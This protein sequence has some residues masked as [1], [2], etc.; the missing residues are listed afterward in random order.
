MPQ[1]LAPVSL[2]YGIETQLIE[3]SVEKIIHQNLPKQYISF[4]LSYFKGDTC[5]ANEII[6][7]SKT[8]PFLNK[9]RIVVVTE[10]EKFLTEQSKQLLGYVESPCKSTVLI[11][12]GT[13]KVKKTTSLFKA[14]KKKN[15]AKAFYAMK[16]P[17]AISWVQKKVIADG[18]EIKHDAAKALVE[19]VGC[20]SKMLMPEV[21]KLKLYT[22][23]RRLI[24]TEDVIKLSSST[25]SFTLFELTDA[26]GRKQRNKALRILD[27][28]IK[29]G[30]VP[31]VILAMIIRQFRLIWYAKVLLEKKSS[32]A[33]IVKKLKIPGFALGNL[34][35]QIPLFTKSDIRNIFKSLH[36][37]DIAM[38][39]SGGNNKRYL[40]DFI[41]QVAKK[42]Q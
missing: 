11:L 18:W 27:K 40:E 17:Q 30:E 12:V 4:N 9:I 26:I 5:S 19:Q 14:L 25:K 37:V 41:F 21:E 7:I 39:T 6:S 24:E 16:G 8:P 42:R 20:E 2:F 32:D 35:P 3:D 29:Q 34:R 22:Y 38:K 31:L 33:E 10:F 23:K 1:P 36:E 13:E 28:N 15:V